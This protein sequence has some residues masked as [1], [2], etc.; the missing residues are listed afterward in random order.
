MP[1]LDNP[2]V[3]IKGEKMKRLCIVIL[4]L[5]FLAPALT[6]PAGASKAIESIDDFKEIK[7]GDGKYINNADYYALDVVEPGIMDKL[8]KAPNLLANGIFRGTVIIVQA[9]C[10]VLYLAS[11]FSFPSLIGPEIDDFQKSL[12]DNMFK[13]SFGLV[14]G[15]VGIFLAWLLLR[16]HF[17]E[18]LNQILKVFL[19]GCMA[20]L[21]ATNTSWVIEL[22]EEITKSFS[23]YVSSAMPGGASGTGYATNIAGEI[24]K[25]QIHRPWISLQFLGADPQ[26]SQVEDLL[27]KLPPG[28]KEREKKIKEWNAAN[29]K[30][31]AWENGFHQLGL[32]AIHI[33]LTLFKC[34]IIIALVLCQ[35]AFRAVKIFLYLLGIPVMII[36]LIP[37]L[38][39][40]RIIAAWIKKIFEISC[41]IVLLS[42]ALSVILW[43]DGMLWQHLAPSGGWLITVIFQIAI[44]VVIFLFRNKILGVLDTAQHIVSNPAPAAA[45]LQDRIGSYGYVGSWAQNMDNRATEAAKSSAVYQGVAQGVAA[46]AGWVMRHG[47]AGIGSRLPKGNIFTKRA[48]EMEQARLENE[49][50]KYMQNLAETNP[51][52]YGAA[53]IKERMDVSKWDADTWDKEIENASYTSAKYMLSNANREIRKQNRGRARPQLADVAYSDNAAEVNAESGSREQAAGSR[54]VANANAVLK[55][56]KAVAADWAVTGE[57]GLER[58]HVTDTMAVNYSHIPKPVTDKFE[59]D[60]ARITTASAGHESEGVANPAN[61]TTVNGV[62]RERPMLNLYENTNITQSNEPSKYQAHEKP[63]VSPQKR[64]VRQAS[65][66]AQVYPANEN[67]SDTAQP[68]PS[69]TNNLGAGQRVV[70]DTSTPAKKKKKLP[71]ISTEEQIVEVKPVNPHDIKKE[72]Q[73]YAKKTGGKLA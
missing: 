23:D 61:K 39:G 41:M 54:Q 21:L 56:E 24:W 69:T 64:P 29:K 44:A 73:P 35:L 47:N 5:I 67:K 15:I 60:P 6:V 27:T 55:Y 8:A 10:T 62:I 26:D 72:R 3:L 51:V 40:T 43:F 12:H 49:K 7:D 52:Q 19:I 46:G 71:T 28:D 36:G 1:V 68:G 33:L 53:R 38:G 4:I 16:R 42:F 58:P 59:F 17:G 9:T 32:A 66:K 34:L 11:E 31:F 13:P 18:I 70:R 57:K 63:L 65:Q 45:Q 30:A 2:Y 20:A 14:F 37:Q 48:E 25:S 22:D 50:E